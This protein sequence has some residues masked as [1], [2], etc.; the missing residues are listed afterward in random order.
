MYP[1]IFLMNPILLLRQTEKNQVSP[2][3][4]LLQNAPPISGGIGM[5]ILKNMGWVPGQGLGRYNQGRTELI[6]LKQLGRREGKYVHGSYS[7]RFRSFN[8]ACL[9]MVIQ[10]Q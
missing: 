2:F 7:I 1:P 5:D 4:P 8:N 10:I 9:A 6:L 3:S